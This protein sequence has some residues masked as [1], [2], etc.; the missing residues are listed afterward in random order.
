MSW[1]LAS[2]LGTHFRYLDEKISP[3]LF[4]SMERTH[5]YTLEDLELLLDMWKKI[6]LKNEVFEMIPS[7]EFGREYIQYLKEIKAEETKVQDVG[8]DIDQRI[9]IFD[10]LFR[11]G[12]GVSYNDWIELF[13]LIEE[14]AVI[15]TG[16]EEAF[17]HD[18]IGYRVYPQILFQWYERSSVH[19]KL[20][21]EKIIHGDLDIVTMERILR[22]HQFTLDDLDILL[23]LMQGA[24]EENDME[25]NIPS[26]DLAREFLLRL[27]LKRDLDKIDPRGQ[28]SYEWDNLG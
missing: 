26:I 1:F 6:L 20:I 28:V 4:V 18:E 7:I 5:V 14:D 16:N 9:K 13:S 17:R 12:H 27:R 11:I 19:E 25:Y 10:S 23:D 3:Q 22:A 24:M 2:S 15:R 8:E 21:T